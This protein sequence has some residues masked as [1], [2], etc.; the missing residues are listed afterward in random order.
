MIEKA[1]RWIIDLTGLTPQKAHFFGSMLIVVLTAIVSILNG[2]TIGYSALI[3]FAIAT[4][5][6]IMLEMIDY[7]AKGYVDMEDVWFDF[8]GQVA[9]ATIYISLSSLVSVM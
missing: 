9:G 6:N 1:K 2:F 4:S 8:G 5:F 7:H 3:G